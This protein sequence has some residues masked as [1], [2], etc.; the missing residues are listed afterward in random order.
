MAVTETREIPYGS[1]DD[2]EEVFLGD[3][4]EPGRDGE[5]WML[6]LDLAVPRHFT[7]PVRGPLGVSL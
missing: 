6:G 4:V 1:D 3:E 5:A 7:W 2:H